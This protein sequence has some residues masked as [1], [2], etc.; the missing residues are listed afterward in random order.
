MKRKLYSHPVR[1]VRI[2]FFGALLVASLQ[3]SSSDSRLRLKKA[4]VEDV[5]EVVRAHE[6]SRGV[7]LNFWA[8]WCEPCVEEFPMIVELGSDYAPQD[9]IVYFVSVDW[10]DE[11]AKALDF[12]KKHGVTGLSFIKDQDDNSFIEGIWHEWTGAVPFTLLYSKDSGKVVDSWEG[13]QPRERFVSAIQ[14]ALRQQNGG[15]R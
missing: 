15:E 10:L 9:L 1:W 3:C 13:K 11:R 8:T 12:L 5:L 6:G 4:G 2:G 14:S 7:L